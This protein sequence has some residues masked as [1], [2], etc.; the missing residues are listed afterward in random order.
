MWPNNLKPMPH[1]NSQV[2]VIESSQSSSMETDNFLCTIG[3]QQTKLFSHI[4]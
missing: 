3:T 4:V 2:N 1:S